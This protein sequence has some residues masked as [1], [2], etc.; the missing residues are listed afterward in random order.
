MSARGVFIG[1]PETGDEAKMRTA[2]W[3]TVSKILMSAE[4]DIADVLGPL[5][6]DERHRPHE[7]CTSVE[8][9]LDTLIWG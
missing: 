7:F 2:F 4:E 8:K 5:F 9:N 3:V 1:W 6:S